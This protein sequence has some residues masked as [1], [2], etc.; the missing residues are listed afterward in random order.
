VLCADGFHLPL[1]DASL[2]AVTLA[3]GLRNLR[4]RADALREIA[5]V[6]R[7]GGTLVV[8]EATAPRPGLLAPLHRF[9]LRRVVPLLGHLSP[10]P[11]AYRYLGESILEFGDGSAFEA[12]LAAAGFGVLRRH[13]F[14]LGAAALWVSRREPARGEIP[15]DSGPIVRTARPAGPR[16]GEFPQPPDPREAERRAWTG[17]QVAVSA[18]LTAALTY[19]LVEYAKL[20]AAFPLQAWQRQAGWVL[21]GG[22][23][24]AFAVRTVA[25][26]RRF[27]GPPSAR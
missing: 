24:V 13:R 16:G 17:G 1:A 22:G 2:D 21:L 7:P 3:F 14:L 12:A 20:N 15:S 4:P 9:H 10:D 11:S 25:L 8:L 23:W 19:G 18:A 27:I 26:W 5:R 6:L